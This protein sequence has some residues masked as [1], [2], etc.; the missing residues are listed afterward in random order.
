VAD[1]T[2]TNVFADRGSGAV[3]T[4]QRSLLTVAFRANHPTEPGSRHLVDDID[5]VSFGRGARA[6]E[7]DTQGGLRRLLL[8]VP[9]PVMSTD[10]GRLLQVQQRWMLED[11]A[12]K[13]GAVVAGR[14]TRAAAVQPG[15]VFELG[16]TLFLLE[17]MEA[18]N[19]LPL[20]A[21]PPANLPAGLAT[22]H[23]GLARDVGLMV[24]V[25]SSE[26]PVL[27]LG[28]TGTGKEVF[29][30]ALHQLS[31]RRGPMVAVNCGGLAPTLL[32]AELFGH[33]R[34]AFSGAVADRLGYLR[35]ADRGTLFLDEVAELSLPGQ[36]ALLR[37]L[38]QREVVPVGDAAPVAIDIRLVAATHRD[39]P[40]LVESGA[41]RADL[42][43]RLLGLTV[44]LPPLRARRC[45][46]G[47]LVG[48][49]LRAIPDGERARFVPAAAYALFQHPF[50]LNIRE[51]ERCLGTAVA[52]AAGAP[53]TAAHLRLPAPAAA[54][55][56]VEGDDGEEG[57]LRATV[58]QALSRHQG[59]VAAV[60]RELGKH[61]EQV[62]RWIRR[63][64]LDVDSFRR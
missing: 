45:D 17:S 28:E 64:G 59:N 47:L 54:D 5:S 53:I 14:P 58:M 35:S 49:L 46:L 23:P 27:L 22:L 34:G 4:R 12:S 37:A 60:A 11:P 43:A 33:R 63:W 26:V 61:R 19:D 25:A 56:L 2:V 52:L 39:L 30:R 6:A 1:P 29:A 9:D 10:H 44:T 55:T 40:A 16:H 24:R 21:A 13:N 8:R 48:S 62:H 32:E 15:D 36:T 42:Y 38:Q 41:F 7:R 20:D 31:G 18:P 51:L 57:T 3:A 50:T